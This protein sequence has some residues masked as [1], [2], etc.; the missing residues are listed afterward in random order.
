MK[1]LLLLFAFLTFSESYNPII[2]ENYTKSLK[3][4]TQFS[5]ERKRCIGINRRNAQCGNN[6]NPGSNYCDW[7]EPNRIRCIAI[8]KSTGRQCNNSPDPGSKY[9]MAHSNRKYN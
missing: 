2:Y 7:H 8:A 4:G 1:Y 5:Q 9:C 3:K 6:A